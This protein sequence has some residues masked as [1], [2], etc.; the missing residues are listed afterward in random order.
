MHDSEDIIHP[1][2]L[3]MTNYLLKEHGGLQ[4]P[5]FPIVEYQTLSNYLKNLTTNTNADEFAEHHYLTMVVRSKMNAFS[6]SWNGFCIE[7]RCYG[8]I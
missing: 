5:V 7:K 8:T 3:R 4:F 2:E 6:F 1:Y